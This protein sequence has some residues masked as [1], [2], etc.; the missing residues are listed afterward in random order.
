MNPIAPL[1]YTSFLLKEI[2]LKE[3][4]LVK[5]SDAAC[6]MRPLG[7]L[8]GVRGFVL[9]LV[10]MGTVDFGRIFRDCDGATNLVAVVQWQLCIPMRR[11]L[12]I[13][14]HR[15]C[16]RSGDCPSFLQKGSAHLHHVAFFRMN[17][18]E[19]DSHQV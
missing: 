3:R 13:L 15:A 7:W 12:P 4:Y 18:A 11:Q 1:A 2:A 16:K 14:L 19:G 6:S 5:R 8:S 17:H 10:I 9:A